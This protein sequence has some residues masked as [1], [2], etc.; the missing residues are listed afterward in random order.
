MGQRGCL[1]A[2]AAV[3]TP[4][5]LA[6]VGA[7]LVGSL[8]CLSCQRPLAPGRQPLAP[9]TPVSKKAVS[10]EGDRT[11]QVWRDERWNV[12]EGDSEGFVLGRWTVRLADERGRSREAWLDGY[13]RADEGGIDGGRA[14]RWEVRWAPSGREL[15][16]TPT[17]MTSVRPVRVLDLGT[18]LRA[19]RPARDPPITLPSPQPLTKDLAQWLRRI[20]R[21][22]EEVARLAFVRVEGEYFGAT[23]REVVSEAD[24]VLLVVGPEFGTGGGVAAYGPILAVGDAHF[25]CPV[26]SASWICFE[27]RSFP[28][29]QVDAT[30]VFLAPTVSTS[31]ARFGPDTIVHWPVAHPLPGQALPPSP[32]E[33]RTPAERPTEAYTVK[34]GQHVFDLGTCIRYVTRE[35]TFLNEPTRPLTEDLK[36]RLARAGLTADGLAGFVQLEGNFYGAASKPFVLMRRDVLLVIGPEFGAHDDVIAFGPIL[37][38]GK[39]HFMCRV[40]SGSW[41]FFDDESRPRNRVDATAVYLGP[42]VGTQH[43]DLR[44]PSAR[45]PAAAP[46]PEKP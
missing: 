23:L 37:A 39:A 45:V 41:V 33:R 13:N 11:A 1:T 42:R 40:S 31:H 19:L 26:A 17:G 5:F 16:C 22:E 34:D 21:P 44:A 14:V 2:L 38:I 8:W 10:P 6:G 20:G 29:E 15:T 9:D 7:G 4:A 36:R 25:M 3:L 32:A 30:E 18:C 24:D 12:D 35:P 28:R 27:G 43:A 46:A